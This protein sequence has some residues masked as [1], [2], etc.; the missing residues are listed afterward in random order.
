MC[1]KIYLIIYTRFDRDG[2][3]VIRSAKRKQM[4]N[5]PTFRGPNLNGSFCP[6]IDAMPGRGVVAPTT[7]STAGLRAIAGVYA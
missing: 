5:V 3:T 1:Y 2:Q 6:P 4:I 7:A